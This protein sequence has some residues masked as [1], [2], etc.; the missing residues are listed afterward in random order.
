MKEAS[1][2]LLMLLITAKSQQE[3]NP[4]V[5][6]EQGVVLNPAGLVAIA[7]ERIRI[8]LMMKIQKPK[9]LEINNACQETCTNEQIKQFI[10]NR[11]YYCIQWNKVPIREAY[12]TFENNGFI[13][14]V[15]K[16]LITCESDNECAWIQLLQNGCKLYKD[17]KII[18]QS[19]NV[20]IASECFLE[21]IKNNCILR[22]Q[23]TDV[24]TEALKE[25]I[26]QVWA[27]IKP[28]LMRF[29]IA[30]NK[31]EKEDS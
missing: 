19:P 18:S 23:Q 20:T 24:L 4:I 5:F 9:L 27:E 31:L 13:N 1:A 12:K 11:D 28:N 14:D 10:I 25:D 29:L 21:R 22:E 6:E 2:W 15:R 26:T 30:I 8:S 7:S 17:T 16:C 3:I